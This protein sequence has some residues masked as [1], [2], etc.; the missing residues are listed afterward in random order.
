MSIPEPSLI[1]PEYPEVIRC[2]CCHRPVM[3]V[4]EISCSGTICRS[5]LAEK[6]ADTVVTMDELS[7]LLCAPVVSQGCD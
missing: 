6:L 4:F 5:C 1:P 7:A 2:Q 3:E